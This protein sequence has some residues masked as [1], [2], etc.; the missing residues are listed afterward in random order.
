MSPGWQVEEILA[1]QSM[2]LIQEKCLNSII[3]Y[4]QRKKK[5][6]TTDYF[7]ARLHNFTLYNQVDL[8]PIKIVDS[9]K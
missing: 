7:R 3:T 9:I 2:L 1:L 6:K 4:Q 8:L 5:T